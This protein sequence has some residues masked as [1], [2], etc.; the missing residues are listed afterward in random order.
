[1]PARICFI[2][3]DPTIRELVAQR[4]TKEG[5][6]VEAR[7]NYRELLQQPASWD[8]W[9]L[10][11]IDLMIH[12]EKQGLE[13]C[14]QLRARL[15]SLPVLILSALSEPLDRVEGLKHGADDYL[16]K[17]F[18]M[19]ELLLRIGGMLKRR[20]WYG[21][22]PDEVPDFRWGECWVDFVKFEGGRGEARFA[23]SVK[24]C[25]L[26]KLLIQRRGQ[27]VGRDEVLEKVWG[28]NVFPSTRTVDNFVSRLRK[29]FEANPAEPA[30]LLS[31][32]GKGYKF[33][34]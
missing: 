12:G 7:E 30:H 3:D 14:G 10:F 31:V 17:P 34:V 8:Q 27:V 5:Y 13:F 9:D 15:P 28:Y 25:M 16:T 19:Q 20:S 18:E 2:E 21:E 24:E 11:I 26:M 32:R 29:Y 6:E 22:L 33:V 1:M 4:L 23:L